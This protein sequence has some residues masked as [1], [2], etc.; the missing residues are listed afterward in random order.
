MLSPAGRL[1]KKRSFVQLKKST[2]KVAV[3]A[4]QKLVR[5]VQHT[6]QRTAQ[7]LQELES[8]HT[9]L[10]HG[11]QDFLGFDEAIVDQPA[12]ALVEAS[13]EFFEAASMA[14]SGT[15]LQAVAAACA[16]L[17][18]EYQE[19]CDSL[20]VWGESTAQQEHY[21]KKV[22]SMDN[23]SDRLVRN[24]G[25]LEQAKREVDQ[26]RQESEAGLNRFSEMRTVH[27]RAS[28]IAFLRAYIGS[29]GKVGS[30]VG[31]VA[32]ALNAELSPGSTV[33]IVGLQRARE[34]NGLDA[35]IVSVGEEG[36]RCVVST[37]TGENKSVRIEH[38]QPKG[39]QAHSSPD[40][41]REDSD[42]EREEK[43]EEVTAEANPLECP[44]IGFGDC[45][46]NVELS[47]GP[48]AP[49][50]WLPVIATRTTGV[51]HS[52]VLTSIPLEPRLEPTAQVK[53][54]Y[55]DFEVREA[56]QKGAT[57]TLALGFAW[58]PSLVTTAQADGSPVAAKGEAQSPGALL[59]HRSFSAVDGRASLPE[60][61]NELLHAFIVGGD[62]P[63][64]RLGGVSLGKVSGWRPLKDVVAGSVL[65]CL[66]EQDERVW[67][68]KIFQ[69]GTC[70]C[71]TEVVPPTWGADPPHG[72]ID[73]C[74]SVRCVELRQSL[75][76]PS[77]TGSSATS[78]G[79][80]P[81][82]I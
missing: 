14:F 6:A 2:G 31:P 43:V 30:T 67:R 32:E 13:A 28:L 5:V 57:R 76:P 45:G 1:R 66:L 48:S 53:R 81:K 82:W 71:E 12:M 38:L 49:P 63:H 50:H 47:R 16:E 29:L 27:V 52:I 65:G 4:Y 22:A 11:I 59:R 20:T 42:A 33:Q 8:L 60:T 40:D 73:V 41:E 54:Y 35:V 7:C 3:E 26:R 44:Q 80:A 17:L 46:R 58:P 24:Q 68:L 25:K 15:G 36:R 39:A 72:V 21:E 61:A 23:G 55:F 37:P 9:G 74:G 79:N 51:L 62:L 75:G 70:R 69:D 19:L 18:A 64:I 56:I 34:L 77:E 78:T 10:M